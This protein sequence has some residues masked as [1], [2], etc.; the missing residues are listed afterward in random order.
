MSRVYVT[1]NGLAA[2]VG[3]QLAAESRRGVGEELQQV[4][5][6]LPEWEIEVSWKNLCIDWGW[7]TVRAAT[8]EEAEAKAL[9]MAGNGEVEFTD[10]E[11]IDG[12]ACE[13]SCMRDVTRFNLKGDII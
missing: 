8:Q 3:P 11:V 4:E 2:V 13:V 1:A 9:E 10:S 6:L 5:K 7:I 12:E